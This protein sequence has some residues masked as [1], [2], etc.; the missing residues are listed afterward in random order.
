[1]TGVPGSTTVCASGTPGGATPLER[2]PQ[3]TAGMAI[4]RCWPYG[5]FMPPCGATAMPAASAMWQ[6][7]TH[8]DIPPAHCRSGWK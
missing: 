8:A 6:M 2:S 7:R 1:M 5:V 4:A 3:V